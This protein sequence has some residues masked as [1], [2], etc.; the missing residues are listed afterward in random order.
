M[1]HL[2]KILSAALFIFLLL[3]S[4]CTNKEASDG[5]KDNSSVPCGGWDTF[6]EVV[7]ACNGKLVKAECPKDASCDSGTYICHGTCGVCTC[8]QGSADRGWEI[9]CEGRN[10]YSGK[11]SG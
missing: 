5:V 9:S 4:M 6:G 1:D 2:P 11:K 3:L 10:T 7:C 8:F